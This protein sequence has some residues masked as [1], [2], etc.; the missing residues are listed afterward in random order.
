MPPSPPSTPIATWKIALGATLGALGLAWFFSRPRRGGTVFTIVMENH[1]ASQ[2]Y[3]NPNCPYMNDIVARYGKAAN[4]RGDVH[5][6]LPNYLLMTSGSTQGVGD[7]HYHL[8]G[9]T[10]NV[11]AQMDA[12]G[13]AWRAY[14]ESMPSPCATGD[15]L[16]YA[17]RHNPAV[18]Y[19]S[20]VNSGSCQ[21]KVVDLST[22][23]TDLAANSVRYAW[24]TPNLRD[25]MH[26]APPATADAW[27]QQVVPQIQASPGYQGGGVIFILW[28]EGDET[29]SASDPTLL[30]AIVVS[31]R[32]TSTP[33]ADFTPYDHRSYLASVQDLLGLPRLATT[34]GVA[35]MAAMLT[36]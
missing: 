14:S 29:G 30:P 35:S 26:D 22:L 9:G 8:I 20:V 4:Y 13:I 25:D 7:D 18:Y 21:D 12:A 24:I 31:E 10:D 11:F 2:I 5:P 3:G 23:W 15:T 16:L 32:L 6:S 27:L 17:S 19:D 33:L 34:D 36:G 1:S 28:D